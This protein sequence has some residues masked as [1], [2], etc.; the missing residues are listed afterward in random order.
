MLHSNAFEYVKT[1]AGQAF[2]GRCAPGF[3]GPRKIPQPVQTIFH[4]TTRRGD[5]TPG[6]RWCPWGVCRAA[7]R[8]AAATRARIAGP[9]IV[10]AGLVRVARVACCPKVR[11]IMGEIR[12]PRCR[13]DLVDRRGIT[14]ADPRRPDLALVAITLQDGRPDLALPFPAR[15]RSARCCPFALPRFRV[16]RAVTR[17]PDQVRAV[18]VVAWAATWCTWHLLPTYRC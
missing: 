8:S 14:D 4:R 2:S 7:R 5:E 9:T 3:A 1:V 17:V 10:R 12:P 11:R 18:A 13:D 6:R 15:R 16:I